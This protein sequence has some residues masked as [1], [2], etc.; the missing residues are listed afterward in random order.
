[1]PQKRNVCP[2]RNA[3]SGAQAAP[4][5]DYDHDA[6]IWWEGWVAFRTSWSVR[7]RLL[8]HPSVDVFTPRAGVVLFLF[9]QA[10]APRRRL[11]LAC[12]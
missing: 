8:A 1:V 4:N 3:R 12:A 10:P 9:D 6:G 2:S 5:C 7:W 11:I